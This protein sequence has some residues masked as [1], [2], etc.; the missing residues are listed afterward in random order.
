MKTLVS[1][2][3]LFTAGDKS[4]ITAKDYSITKPAYVSNPLNRNDFSS[5]NTCPGFIAGVK[6]CKELF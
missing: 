6:E 5:R 4:L 2:A 1:I 3:A